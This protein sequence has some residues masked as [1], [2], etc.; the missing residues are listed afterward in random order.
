[1]CFAG[2][3]LNNLNVS[4]LSYIYFFQSHSWWHPRQG[5][6]LWSIPGVKWLWVIYVLIYSSRNIRNEIFG[7][8]FHIAYFLFVRFFSDSSLIKETETKL[9]PFPW[10]TS[11]QGFISVLMYCLQQIVKTVSGG[12]C[13]NFGSFVLLLFLLSG[14]LN[15][16]VDRN[17]W[18][19]RIWVR[20]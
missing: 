19:R 5:Y 3:S 2:W 10:W 20:I 17:L 4:M 15:F 12:Y 18:E 7:F 16:V 11:V 14:I 8:F 6:F 9:W 1:M 13:F